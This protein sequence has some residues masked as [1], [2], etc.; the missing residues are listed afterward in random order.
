[1]LDADVLVADHIAH[2]GASA[3]WQDSVHLAR[4]LDAKATY[5]KHLRKEYTT[6]LFAPERWGAKHCLATNQFAKAAKW[7]K[8]TH[9]KAVQAEREF[10]TVLAGYKE[11]A[12]WLAPYLAAK[13]KIT[14]LFPGN[15]SSPKSIWIREARHAFLMGPVK[16]MRESKTMIENAEKTHKKLKDLIEKTETQHQV[17]AFF[18]QANKNKPGNHLAAS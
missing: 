3:F 6:T 8:K 9:K 5:L 12:A 17:A 11:V 7:Y 16:A 15:I 10:S 18:K 2:Q 14:P 13:E 4:Q 1:M